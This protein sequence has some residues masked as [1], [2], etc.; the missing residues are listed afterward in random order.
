MNYLFMAKGAGRKE[1]GRKGARCGHSF[2][3]PEK[4]GG[5]T[6]S[7]E[8]RK[9]ERLVFFST[10]KKAARRRRR[11]NDA[12]ISRKKKKGGPHHLFF[13][14][15]RSVSKILLEKEIAPEKKKKGLAG[16]KKERQKIRFGGRPMKKEKGLHLLYWG[17]KSTGYFMLLRGRKKAMPCISD[18]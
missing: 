4:N 15:K 13:E 9:K 12:Y 3:Q 16:E 18:H 5:G 7:P 14:K 11:I 8:K 10:G 1:G 2:R 6:S 17:E